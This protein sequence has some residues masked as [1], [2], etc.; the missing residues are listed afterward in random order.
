MCVDLHACMHA[1]MHAYIYSYMNR[2]FYQYEIHMFKHNVGSVIYKA[3]SP[4]TV[5]VMHNS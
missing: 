5:N 2:L 3:A 1:C 4:F